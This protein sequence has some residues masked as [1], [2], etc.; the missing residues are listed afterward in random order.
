LNFL[1]V[2]HFEFLEA[3]ERKQEISLLIVVVLT[4]WTM[5]TA[6]MGHEAMQSVKTCIDVT[7][8]PVATYIRLHSIAFQ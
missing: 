3:F 2:G 8:D 7:E 5:K 6:V 4:A 1:R